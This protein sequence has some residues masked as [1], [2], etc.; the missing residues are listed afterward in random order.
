MSRLTFYY[1]K[2]LPKPTPLKQEYLVNQVQ[3]LKKIPQNAQKSKEWYEMRNTMISA[4]DW[5]T[6]IGE[7]HFGTPEDILLKKCGDDKPFRTCPAMDWG[8]K[9][10]D[11][12]VSVYEHRNKLTVI[13]FGCIRHPYV[14]FLGA[15]PDGI[16]HDGVM[17]EIKCPKSREITGIPPTYYWCQV[18]GQLEVCELDRCDFL[19]CNF[20][21][22]E[23]E[24]DYL[25]DNYE[26]NNELNKYGNEKGVI[27]EFYRKSDKTLF[28]Q[29]SP[30]NII[31]D[32]LDNWKKTMMNDKFKQDNNVFF[33][34]F[35]YWHLVEV[36]CVPIYRN[37][38]WFQNI[39]LPNLTL[40]WNKVL[41]YRELGLDVLK[42][43]IEIMKAEKKKV[44]EEKKQEKLNE[45]LQEKQ[46]KLEKK[47]SSTSSKKQK[48]INDF[49]DLNNDII[50]Q[51]E[52]VSTF[53]TSISYD[54]DDIHINSL[55]TSLFSSNEYDELNT[56]NEHTL[57]KSSK[58]SLFSD[59]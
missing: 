54:D 31:S 28:F 47:E 33:S 1:D 37:Q 20:K 35:Y 4:S 11:V 17:L 40:F 23:T 18:Q 10:E 53:E 5:A 57:I 59:D 45:K 15:S 22:Y 52:P 3:V 14:S 6:V 19:E 42:S 26:G 43:D 36:S 48:K 9:Y 24:D 25:E 2:D 50:L 38:E 30:V 32:Q 51:S 44:R 13:D 8:N 55:K 34:S 12:A 27:A 39:A 29:Y 16:T 46:E 41:H 7:G 49:I 56:I 58:L 21:E